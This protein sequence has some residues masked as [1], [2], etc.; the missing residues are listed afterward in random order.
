MS[1]EPELIPDPE[2]RPNAYVD[3]AGGDV[4]YVLRPGQTPAEFL[5]ELTAAADPPARR[6]VPKS[7]IVAR[8]NAAGL[9]AAAKGALDAD[10]YARER[11]YAPDRPAVYADDPEALHWLLRAGSALGRFASTHPAEPAPTMMKS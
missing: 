10:L 1:G 3:A 4:L 7:L 8:L 5:A 11:W 2:G 9:L 6:L